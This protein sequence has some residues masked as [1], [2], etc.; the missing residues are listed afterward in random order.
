MP[1]NIQPLKQ[2][3]IRPPVLG[4]ENPLVRSNLKNQTPLTE[5]N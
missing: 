3:E 1:G 2:P 4:T 5:T